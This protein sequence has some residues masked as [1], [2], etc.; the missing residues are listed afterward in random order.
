MTKKVTKKTTKKKVTK[1]KVAK[2]VAAK[3]NGRPSAYQKRYALIAKFMCD[4]GATDKEIAE[5][6][7]HSE[8]TINKWK[9][10]YPEFSESLK[11]GKKY[12][13]NKVEM[14]LAERA[15]GYTHLEEKIFNYNGEILRA[16]TNKH[17]PPDVTACIYWL[18]NRKP[19][20][21]ASRKAVETEV[22][23]N[24]LPEGAGV[25]MT[26]PVASMEDW[27]KLSKQANEQLTQKEKEFEKNNG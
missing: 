20:D 25:L 7:Q 16:E 19:K 18:N 1:K 2:K 27:I 17:Y 15:I 13:D 9:H 6:L 12:F 14:A 8:S 24:R 22:N 11:R 3:K 5:C 26:P 4:R 21:W 23:L 10:D